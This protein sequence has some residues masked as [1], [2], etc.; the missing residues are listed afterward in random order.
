MRPLI[1]SVVVTLAGLV[2]AAERAHAATFAPVAD[3]NGSARE[4]LVGGVPPA[5]TY[6]RFHVRG[7][8]GRVTRATLRL[9][10]KTAST[11]GLRV[12][13]SETSARPRSGAFRARTWI[14]VDVTRLVHGNG[15]LTLVLTSAAPRQIRLASRE[16]ARPP[17]LVV[18]TTAV[19]LAAGDIASCASTGD[20]ATAALLDGLRGTILTLGDNAYPVGSSSDFANCYDPSWGRHRA[21]TRPS[22]GN[23]DYGTPGAAPLLAYFGLARTWYAFDL[24][25]WRL[26][27]LDSEAVTAE[28]LSWLRSDLA[29]APRRC[30]LAYWHRP[31][32]SDGPHG[33]SAA[34]EPLWRAL[35]EAG[36]DVVLAGHDHNY[37]RFGPIDGMRSFVVG[38]GGASHYAVARQQAEVANGDAFGVLE[39]TLRPAGFGW[40]FLQVAGHT[41]TDSGSADC[42]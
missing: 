3:G 29:V 25:E 16:S 18:E 38:T 32:F 8:S 19:V 20:E 34:V 35:A 42:R 21:R 36:A 1:V 22:P 10:V 40:R 7:L 30:V 23:H 5:R 27:A 14:R 11:R 13:R 41:F 28:Q 2:I 6:V 9:Y 12:S 4:V 17:R 26:Y 33:P 39:L 15:R 31:R 24:G 37:Q